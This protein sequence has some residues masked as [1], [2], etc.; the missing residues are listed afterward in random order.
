MKLTEDEDAFWTGLPDYERAPSGD[1][2]FART[3]RTGPPPGDVWAA[4]PH[5]L[6]VGDWLVLGGNAY[7]ITNMFSRGFDCS[8]KRVILRGHAPQL[9]NA[10]HEVVRPYAVSRLR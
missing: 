3:V 5:E 2:L 6:R 4:S 7:E 8:G 1:P 10:R 9:V